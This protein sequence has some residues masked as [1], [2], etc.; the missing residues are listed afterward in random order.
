V[1]SN[2]QEVDAY[3]LQ[4]LR[5]LRAKEG[6]GQQF[7]GRRAADMLRGIPA[8]GLVPQEL[9]A[10]PMFQELLTYISR[11]II[12]SPV[13]FPAWS[14]AA[15][16]MEI[17]LL[18]KASHRGARTA[19]YHAEPI[20]R[21]VTIVALAFQKVLPTATG[22]ACAHILSA[23]SHV[24]SPA[25]ARTF[26]SVAA[27]LVACESV[28]VGRPGALLLPLVNHPAPG[29]ADAV[30]IEHGGQTPAT[31][32][33]STAAAARGQPDLV[34]ATALQRAA[35]LPADL[36]RRAAPPSEGDE[37]ESAL[38]E[39]IEASA[40]P[41]RLEG[42]AP[43]AV[44]EAA[45][46]RSAPRRRGAAAS[47]LAAAAA[48]AQAAGPIAMRDLTP[49]ACRALLGDLAQLS[50]LALSA[51]VSPL[52]DVTPAL[53]SRMMASLPALVRQTTT[54][55]HVSSA[56]PA[57][58]ATGA[59][60]AGA[61]V[62]GGAVEGYEATPNP[63]A[64]APSQLHELLLR[65]LLARFI[66]QL[67]HFPPSVGG[68]DLVRC[69]SALRECGLR[70][71]TDDSAAA[72]GSPLFGHRKAAA[73]A[74]PPAEPAPPL[75][76][77]EVVSAG[78]AHLVRVRMQQPPLREGPIP[79]FFL[80]GRFEPVPAASPF[81]TPE[82][83][84]AACADPAAE[85]AALAGT[86]V[87]LPLQGL[88]DVLVQCAGA[89]VLTSQRLDES[90]ITLVSFV[91]A[92]VPVAGPWLRPPAASA[93]MP[94]VVRRLTAISDSGSDAALRRAVASERRVL[95]AAALEA[96]ASVAT[97]RVQQRGSED[98]GYA[99][100]MKPSEIA[101]SALHLRDSV[102]LSLTAAPPAVAPVPAA[103]A[104]S[105]ADADAEEQPRSRCSSDAS[106]VNKAAPP[107]V[108]PAIEDCDTAVSQL[109]LLP[110]TG[111]LHSSRPPP[112]SAGSRAG[113]VPHAE[114]FTS[115]HDALPALEAAVATYLGAGSDAT[116]ENAPA[117][118]LHLLAG[119]VSGHS[120]LGTLTS[121]L[122]REC[123]EAQAARAGELEAL[124][125]ARLVD[126]AWT[127]ANHLALTAA[128]AAPR[129][130]ALPRLRSGVAARAPGS[131]PTLLTPF[132]VPF[133]DDDR[134]AGAS[135]IE[136]A[137]SGADR[138]RLAAASAASFSASGRPLG[139][140]HLLAQA[141]DVA[142]FRASGQ[143]SPLTAPAVSGLTRTV[144][145]ALTRVLD[146]AVPTVQAMPLPHLVSLL[147]ACSVANVVHCPL[148]SAA[149][150]RLAAAATDTR[151]GS[152]RGGG[153][154][155]RAEGRSELD[156]LAPAVVSLLG[157]ASACGT[158]A[159]EHKP[160]TTQRGSRVG[161]AAQ[162]TPSLAA[163]LR[164]L[165]SRVLDSV[166]SLSLP[167]QSPASVHAYPAAVVGAT[168]LL[169][170]LLA[171]RLDGRA[172]DEAG[173]RAD[174]EARARRRASS[175]AHE[176][177]AAVW[178]PGCVAA[179][180]GQATSRYA[181]LLHKSLAAVGDTH[182][183]SAPA[184]ARPARFL[185]AADAL[186]TLPPA[187]GRGCQEGIRLA[188]LHYPCSLFTAEPLLP[189]AGVHSGRTAWQHGEDGS[190][191]H[192]TSRTLSQSRAVVGAAD[193]RWRVAALTAL[194]HHVVAVDAQAFV[195]AR[196]ATAKLEYLRAV[197]AP[198]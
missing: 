47:A 53:L 46:A 173:Y 102:L 137:S 28:H 118:K 67:V 91:E 169:Q 144:A 36:L 80:R 187:E 21:F 167:H 27:W 25:T 114:A 55:Q 17:V 125:P 6:A 81:T 135:A 136:A 84:V 97:Q 160:A 58:D 151:A 157:W 42:A 29:A 134:D 43:A 89:W 111:A 195:S 39:E 90:V 52:A 99:S 191:R 31:A 50:G 181:K 115:P 5:V 103:A 95:V 38:R 69:L 180:A 82:S 63:A 150:E 156:A 96:A 48:S 131:V 72:V 126:A 112:P 23:L 26:R 32:A 121:R 142:L 22:G 10:S 101:L 92:F 138:A 30:I 174:A 70:V 54:A 71:Q 170:S 185:V 133:S 1:Q 145:A 165:W 183:E 129:H 85:R 60:G 188:V 119:A 44:E 198:L 41:P 106:S 9:L 107:Q 98:K 182:A 75:S 147:S 4:C 139:Q 33:S 87:R 113:I 161:T 146:A 24:P 168:G 178:E 35:L 16:A 110:L 65:S 193:F 132:V 184:S 83:I 34:A 94:A 13:H 179:V 130:A 141:Q 162:T 176:S 45:P 56:A 20:T 61:G 164:P 15:V 108:A 153:G 68:A 14:L 117:T 100:R 194:G 140:L 104:A 57:P 197:G 143:L 192:S 18:P 73:P 177:G 64:T 196:T 8:E 105:D 149:A 152:G 116:C 78:A 109:H 122:M 76:E 74:Q 2:R 93:D 127:F 62:R 171:P 175:G 190:D 79:A 186:V 3:L 19:F 12:R 59:G 159:V 123:A 51:S 172:A 189:T 86:L 124:P 128:Q 158:L 120:L 11:T 37:Y 166:G 155:S 154:S 77:A 40:A 88:V 7:D 66:V 148:L 49:G 163:T